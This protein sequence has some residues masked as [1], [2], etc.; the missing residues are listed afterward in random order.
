MK[1]PDVLFYENAQVELILLFYLVAV[2]CTTRVEVIGNRKA[3][4][5][6][7]DATCWHVRSVIVF[8]MTKMPLVNAVVCNEYWRSVKETNTDGS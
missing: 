8:D 2:C 5:R 1:V 4:F 6:L 7:D 3:R